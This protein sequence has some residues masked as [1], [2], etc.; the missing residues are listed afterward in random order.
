MPLITVLALQP[1]AADIVEQLEAE[2]AREEIGL[3]IRQPYPHIDIMIKCLVTRKSELPV[4]AQV[5]RQPQE[6]RLVELVLPKGLAPTHP[7]GDHHPRTRIEARIQRQIGI[8]LRIGMT[9]PI[10]PPIGAIMSFP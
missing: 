7:I 10:Q 4:P 5:L 6:L 9:V 3:E 2:G 1:N 8:Q